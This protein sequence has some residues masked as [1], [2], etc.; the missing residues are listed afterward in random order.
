MIAFIKFLTLSLADALLPYFMVMVENPHFKVNKTIIIFFIDALLIHFIVP[1][2]YLAQIII[3]GVSL[4]LV[5]NKFHFH[6]YFLIHT[7]LR[8]ILFSILD[9]L[10]VELL[11]GMRFRFWSPAINEMILYDLI[12]TMLFMIRISI[13][14][15]DRQKKITYK[16][17]LTV[18]AGIF[19]FCFLLSKIYFHSIISHEW[20]YIILSVIDIALM[21]SVCSF[22][23]EALEQE[24]IVSHEK[25]NSL[26]LNHLLEIEEQYHELAK[27][28]HDIKNN[29]M[30]LS[31]LQK[32][33]AVQAE[34]FLNDLLDG[35]SVTVNENIVCEHPVINALLIRKMQEYPAIHFQI[36]CKCSR[37]LFVKDLHLNAIFSNL[38]DNAVEYVSVH[39]VPK[40]ISITCIE[41]GELLMIQVTNPVTDHYDYI[42]RPHTTKTD[43]LHHGYGSLIV[44]DAAHYYD[45]DVLTKVDDHQ[46]IVKVLLKK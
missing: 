35:L 18:L 23:R 7:Y 17:Y 37:N 3:L 11:S 31:Y 20:T 24:Q 5:K 8:F 45:G 28:K 2:P 30:T 29:L 41:H 13:K 46:Y 22:F 12:L 34:S 32:E 38:L 40:K 9:L 25:I 1:A 44:K 14:Q 42:E 21:M 6:R 33:N 43:H 4:I 10:I 15:S 19:G 27:Y 26:K 36:N 39:Q 16:L